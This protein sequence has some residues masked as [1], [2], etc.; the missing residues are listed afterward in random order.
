MNQRA[1]N[2]RLRRMG[3]GDGEAVWIRRRLRRLAVERACK[4]VEE[5]L[6]DVGILGLRCQVALAANRDARWLRV[7]RV[8]PAEIRALRPV[9]EFPMYGWQTAG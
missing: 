8:R 4:R 3:E 1:K 5:W 7:M 2:R 6:L 9:A